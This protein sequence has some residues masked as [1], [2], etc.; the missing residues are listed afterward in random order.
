MGNSH[1]A[2][3]DYKAALE[4][5]RKLIAIYPNSQ[6][7]PDAMLNVASCQT[8]L[9]DAAGARKTLEELVAKFPVSD[10]AERAQKRLGITRN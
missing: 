9:G 6:K 3:R 4:A 5:Q 7:V 1:F 2:Q 8:E 10:A